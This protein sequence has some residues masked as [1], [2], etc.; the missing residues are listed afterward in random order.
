M[1]NL[2][3]VARR[4]ALAA[5]I[6]AFAVVGPADAAQEQVVDGV[7]HIRNP[8]EPEMGVV[9]I[10]PERMWE[11]GD[12]D[13]DIMF[14]VTGT[15][16][17]D[18]QGNAYV[19]DRQLSEIQVF[20]ENG[21]WL[22]TIGREGEGPGEFQNAADIFF[23]IGGSIGVMQLFPGK[24]VQM[25]TDGDPAGTYPLGHDGFVQMQRARL[26]DGQLLLAGSG[27]NRAN[28][29]MIRDGFLQIISPDGELGTKFASWSNELDFSTLRFEEIDLDGFSRHWTVGTQNRVFA[30]QD[31]N[32]YAITVW[33]ADGSIDRII[34]RDYKPKERD[35]ERRSEVKDRF[36]ININGRNAEVLTEEYERCVNE[37][38][39]RPNG[40]IWVRNDRGALD[41]PDGILT[42]VDEFDAEGVYTRR[43]DF[44]MP[45]D[46]DRDAV[47]FTGDRVFVTKGWADAARTLGPGR[48]GT[49]DE[50]ES[51]TEE[52]A[53][54][55]SVIS[56]R[57]VE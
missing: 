15:V 38:Y 13:D 51:E 1:S 22:R 52:L 9:V 48:R 30:A 41:P 16:L 25:T 37:I 8:A 4:A 32:S 44:K 24:I 21:E 50:E 57:I 39:P 20:D 3:F 10:E 17:C 53:E 28:G 56:Y 2:A 5:F 54:P 47:G 7:R 29:K 14:G 36:Q 34:E 55:L 6:C 31:W 43:I 45:G 49:Q 23:S 27:N 12:E 19:L 40:Y 18:E 42:W 33:N 46:I 11:R 35:D 26:L